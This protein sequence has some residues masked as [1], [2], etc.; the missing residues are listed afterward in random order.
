MAE[1]GTGPVQELYDELLDVA[2]LDTP[3]LCRTI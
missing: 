1:M 2:M 3:R